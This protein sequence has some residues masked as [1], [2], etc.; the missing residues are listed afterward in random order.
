MG[1]LDRKFQPISTVATKNYF[2]SD[3]KMLL[4]FDSESSD[5]LEIAPR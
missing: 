4:R 3:K 1:T 5:P 2:D